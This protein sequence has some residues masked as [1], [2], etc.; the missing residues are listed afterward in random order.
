[1]LPLVVMGHGHVGIRIILG[2]DQP[3]PNLDLTCSPENHNPSFLWLQL[4]GIAFHGVIPVRLAQFV[5]CPS[6]NLAYP[7]PSYG[8]L[9]PNLLQ[10]PG[11][12]II[13]TKPHTNDG[14]LTGIESADESSYVILKHPI[15]SHIA[16]FLF[17]ITERVLKSERTFATT[18]SLPARSSCRT[19]GLSAPQ[20]LLH[21]YR[22]N[23]R[24]LQEINFVR[25][26]ANL[27]ANLL[28]CGLSPQLIPQITLRLSERP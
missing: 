5:Q 1:M 6:L 24:P 7:L 26:D 19:L 13:Q 14:L 8:K 27:H 17:R 4:G 25:L 28:L 2:T 3:H 22:S 9:L 15:L 21:G 20:L 11:T 23:G 18:P 12:T 10:R 16:W